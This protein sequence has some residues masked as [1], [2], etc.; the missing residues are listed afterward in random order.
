MTINSRMIDDFNDDGQDRWIFPVFP[1]SQ[2]QVLD[3][4]NQSRIAPHG[5][6][7]PPPLADV[8]KRGIDLGLSSCTVDVR[9]DY[10]AVV[11]HVNLTRSRNG[12]N[13]A[14]WTIPPALVS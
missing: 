7:P 10:R 11:K 5:D 1:G 6:V 3:V 4:G 9:M 2:F 14:Q 8:A 12:L 13:L